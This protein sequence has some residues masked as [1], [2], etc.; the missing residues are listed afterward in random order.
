MEF[1]AAPRRLLLALV[2]AAPLAPLA[3]PAT[4]VQQEV[5]HLLEYIANSG[6]NFYRNGNWGAAALAA[7]HARTK[8][9]YLS[10]HEE[11]GSAADF[12]AKAASQSSVTG[13]PY[14]VKCYGAA[15]VLTRAWLSE[16]LARYRARR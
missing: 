4:T 12:I 15:P 16:E 6:C 14:Q 11:I 7:A 10:M 2:L 1:S 9:D 5:N 3:A 13:L 8:F